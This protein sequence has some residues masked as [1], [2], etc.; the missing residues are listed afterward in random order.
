MILR[1]L[2]NEDF[3]LHSGRD[4]DLRIQAPPLV[5]GKQQEW[6]L[7]EMVVGHLL[8]MSLVKS[9]AMRLLKQA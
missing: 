8:A 6:V 7:E 1:T 5:A 4:Q 9:R 2:P 3:R